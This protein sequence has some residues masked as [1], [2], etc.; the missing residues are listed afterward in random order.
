MTR[1]SFKWKVIEAPS[2][3][4]SLEIPELRAFGKLWG[5]QRVRLLKHNVL[6]RFQERMARW[7]SIETGVIEKIYDIS[8]GA[9]RVLIEQGFVASLVAHGDTNVDPQHLVRILGDHRDALEMVLDLVG[10]SRKLT[11]SWIK[12]LHALMTRSQTST[13]ALT[14]NG[15]LVEIP[16]LRGDWKTQPNNPEQLDGTIHEYCPRNMSLRRWTGSSR[17]M[18]HC[19]LSFPKSE[20]PGCIMRS[21]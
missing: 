9:T 8:A 6:D 20:A 10:G 13:T 7:W 3:P 11:T 17:S 2:D 16:L 15:E 4:K 14:S 21:Q 5:Q 18:S 12:E 19:R 1:V